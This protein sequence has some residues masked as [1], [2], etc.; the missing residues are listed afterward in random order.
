MPVGV[1][2]KISVQMYYM[3]VIKRGRK[4]KKQRRDWYQRQT[5]DEQTTEMRRETGRVRD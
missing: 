1:S 3:R 5:Q 2:T 4:R